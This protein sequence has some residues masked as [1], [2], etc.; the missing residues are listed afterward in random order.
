MPEVTVAI[1]VRNG[2]ERF[3]GV[4]AALRA[5]TVEHELLVCDSGSSDGTPELAREHGARVLEIAPEGFSH[6]GT[7]NLL[8]EAASGEHVALLTQDAEPAAADWLASPLSGFD[9]GEEVALVYGPYRPRPEASMP[10]R[11]E[12]ERWF[13]SLSLDG[14]PQLER[15]QQSERS[16]PAIEL[17]GRRGFFTDAN[18]CIAREAWRRVPFREVAYAE[19][20]VLALDM[21]RAGYAKAFLPGAAVLH[22]HEYTAGEELRRC[23]DEWRGLLEVYGW[24]ESLSPAAPLGRLRGGAAR[25][26]RR[27]AAGGRPAQALARGSPGLRAPGAGRRADTDR[28]GTLHTMSQSPTEGRPQGAFSNLRRRIH[29]TYRYFGLRTILFRALTFPLRFTPLQRRLCLRT[30]ARD[31]ELRRAGHGY[32]EHARP[33]D[34]VI[35]S[36]RDAEHVRTLVR[37]IH[38]TAAKGMARVIVADDASGP[39]HVAALRRIEGIDELIVGEQNA[40]FAANVNRGLLATAEDRDVVVLNSDTE[41]L[42]SWLECLQYAAHRHEDIGIVGAQLQYPDGRIQFGGTVRNRDKPQWFDH[43][44]RFKPA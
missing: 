4:L 12:L 9:L 8:M 13:A 20:R 7:R 16:R 14:G 21:L 27:P 30:H 24:R 36:Y 11:L 6:G 42:P 5:Q 26:P 1:P 29:L 10:V 18:A 37:S 43:R 33:V 15:L 3:A 32:R 17:M 28:R 31:Q 23:F 19:D 34:T 44:Y 38:K 40:G 41:A 39:E 2:G 25:L 35:P 22:S